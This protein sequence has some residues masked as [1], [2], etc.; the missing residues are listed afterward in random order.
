MKRTSWLAVAWTMLVASAV[1]QSIPQELWGKWI[2]RRE[3]PASTISCWS[4]E[5]AKAILGSEIEYTAE[6]FRWKSSIEKHA[7][8]ISVIVTA[9]QFHD[10]NSGKG[11]NSSQVSFGQLGIQKEAARQVTIKHGLAVAMGATSE[12]PGEAVLLKSRNA[13]VFSVCNVYFEARRA[14]S[15]RSSKEQR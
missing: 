13:I 5:E 8:A 7:T 3:L 10:E 4:D 12:I 6:S 15:P 14:L 2:I 11:A 1:G 9:D